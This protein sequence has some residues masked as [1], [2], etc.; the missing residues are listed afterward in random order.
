MSSPPPPPPSLLALPLE[1]LYVI[2]S[3]L[4]LSSL[5]RLGSTCRRLHSLVHR[6]DRFWRF[7]LRKNHRYR[8]WHSDLQES[9]S[10]DA[11]AADAKALVRDPTLQGDVELYLIYDK[12]FQAM[13]K[14]SRES[15]DRCVQPRIR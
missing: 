8:L 12:E 9:A 3:R 15:N 5:Y 13:L 2:F 7:R 1:V 10:D 14:S 6:N 11:A 4:P